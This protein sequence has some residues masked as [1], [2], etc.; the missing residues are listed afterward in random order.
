MSSKLTLPSKRT[1][2]VSSGPR[3]ITEGKNNNLGLARG[4]NIQVLG[5]QSV[6]KLITMEML[7][8]PKR[9]LI[10]SQQRPAWPE[11][12]AKT[13][14]HSVK[15]VKLPTE[16]SGH[17]MAWLPL[18]TCLWNFVY[19]QRPS[20]HRLVLGRWWDHLRVGGRD[21]GMKLVLN[22]ACRAWAEDMRGW[23]ARTESANS[24]E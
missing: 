4:E 22:P 24:V 18:C 21:M 16:T 17:S 20:L 23:L 15:Q 14:T 3:S 10:F 8:S 1:H 9:T 2:G 19:T 12:K 5:L 7:T 13:I 11:Q 6:I